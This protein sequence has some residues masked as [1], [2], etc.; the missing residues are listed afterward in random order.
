VNSKNKCGTLANILI[1][2]LIIAGAYFIYAWI[3]PSLYKFYIQ[4][5]STYGALFLIVYAY[6]VI[7]LIFY[8]TTLALGCKI[9]NWLKGFF[10]T[11][12]FLLLGYGVGMIMLVGYT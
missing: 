1:P 7:D 2:L 10:S 11:I 9:D 6:P 5:L 3:L 4:N 8:S 12:H